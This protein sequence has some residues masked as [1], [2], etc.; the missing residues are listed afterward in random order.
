MA[1]SGLTSDRSSHSSAPPCDLLACLHNLLHASH[2]TCLEPDLDAARVEGG[3][4]ENVFHD[5]AGQ[6][7]GA[8]ILLLRDVY[9]E[10]WLDVF[11]IITVHL[12]SLLNVAPCFTHAYRGARG[13]MCSGVTV[14]STRGSV[15]HRAT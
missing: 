2:F 13:A 5:A 11:A 7:P 14:G 9:P 8:L 1:V 3:L 10:P 15:F 12:C 4:R 6:S